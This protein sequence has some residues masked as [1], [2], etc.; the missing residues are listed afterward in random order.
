MV[1]EK[2]KKSSLAIS[3]FIIN[4][5]IATGV[6]GY[7]K[8]KNDEKIEKS[9]QA[10]KAVDE[11]AQM[12]ADIANQQIQID[13][14]AIQDAIA[15]DRKAKLDSVANN[16]GQVTE[17]QSQQVVKSVPMQTQIQK[18]VSNSQPAPTPSKTTKTS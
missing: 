12:A 18:P 2:I 3:V 11:Q 16:T 15:A 9:E 1:L 8:E 4:I 14:N 5:L 17:Q 10:K 6:A 13:A 7:L